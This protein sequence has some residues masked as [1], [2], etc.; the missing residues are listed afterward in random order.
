MNEK[1][2]KSEE[3]KSRGVANSVAQTRSNK[4]QGLGI[5]DNRPESVTQ[6]KLVEMVGSSK[7]DS[8]EIASDNGQSVRQENGL[9]QKKNN[10][11]IAPIQRVPI[12]NS[13]MAILFPG[14]RNGK[15]WFFWGAGGYHVGA[16]RENDGSGDVNEFHVKKEFAGAKTNRIDWNAA[17]DTYNEVDPP[18]TLEHD[19]E[20]ALTS[21]RTLGNQTKNLLVKWKK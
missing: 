4:N 15:E 12:S 11:T 5:L 14:G 18:T 16:I 8:P 10:N 20:E 7:Q 19:D 13:N 2:N 1:I 3:N 9:L 21:M 17:G 6:K